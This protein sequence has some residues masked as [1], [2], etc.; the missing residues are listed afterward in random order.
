MNPKMFPQLR[1]FHEWGRVWF[2]ARPSPPSHVA[3][4]VVTGCSER[5]SF[6]TSVEGT[7]C[8][9]PRQNPGTIV[10][11]GNDLSDPRHTENHCKK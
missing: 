6:G 7:W 10:I 11:L 3:E 9:I 2:C 4:A 5:V 8:P 1:A